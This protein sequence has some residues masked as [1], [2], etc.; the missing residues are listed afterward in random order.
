MDLD[1]RRVTKN[2][3]T[4]NLTMKEFDILAV[5][6]E[7]KGRVFTRDMLLDQ[8]LSLIHIYHNHTRGFHQLQ[9]QGMK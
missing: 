4:I 2:G 1:R 6:M 3:R 7:N 5:L 8:V 9:K